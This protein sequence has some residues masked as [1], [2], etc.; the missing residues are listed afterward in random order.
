[1]TDG[2]VLVHGAMHTSAC[3]SRLL[4]LL[5]RPPL[6][7]DLPGRCG[8]PGDLA[9]IGLEDCVA[10]VLED[11]DRAGFE[12]FALVGHSLGGVTVTEIAYRYPQRVSHLVYVGAL[13]VP[14][15]TT[16]ARLMLGADWEGSMEPGDDEFA[17]SLFGNDLTDEQWAEHAAQLVPE[18][19]G[20]MNARLSGHPTGI[21]ITYVRMSEDVPVP[22]A[23]A[24][25]MV[26]N[27]ASRVDTR[28][29]DAGHSV[30]V[31]R[32]EALAAIINEVVT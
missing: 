18:A 20:L 16:A 28:T 12:T 14:L 6:A 3:W 29:I 10:A 2:I 7:V 11:A 13:V 19:P 4:P 8:R 5:D 26:A 27:L 25:R 24:D 21:P 23:T 30:M 22:P 15:G 31:S 32:P 1:M 9:T 17:R